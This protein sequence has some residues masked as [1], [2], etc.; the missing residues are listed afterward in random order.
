MPT[1]TL[2]RAATAV[3]AALVLSG[4]AAVSPAAA[5]E[6]VPA[7]LVHYDLDGD[8]FLLSDLVPVVGE[9]PPLQARPVIVVFGAHWCEPCHAVVE[10]LHE[11]RPAID[12]A[13]AHVV[14]VHVDDVDRTA[15]LSRDEIR[16]LVAAMA[17]DD[18]FE[19][20]RVLLG[21]DRIEVAQWVPGLTVEELPGV[22]LV[23]ADGLVH[24]VAGGAREVETM[25]PG[26]LASHAADPDADAQRAPAAPEHTDVRHAR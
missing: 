24:G 10:A 19:G 13:G 18:A 9:F 4:L 3:L 5:Q 15:G 21:G 1:T 11:Q 25:L 7:N 23:G 2:A 8:R 14:F 16:T 6:P 12:A 26:F 20:V 22:V 17:E